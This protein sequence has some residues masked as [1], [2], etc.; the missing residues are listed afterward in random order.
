MEL[1]DI[2]QIKK[3]PENPRIIKN[4]KFDKLVKSIE[5][6]P[7]M[8]NIRPIVVDENY[9]VLGGNM[10]LRAC[11]KAGLKQVPVIK[12]DNLTTEQKKEFV[13]KDNSNFGEWDWT[14]LNSDW[15]LKLLDDWGIDVS[16]KSYK[17]KMDSNNSGTKLSDRFIAPPFSILDTKQGYWQER[18]GYWNDF[19]GEKG[20]SREGTLVKDSNC[21]YNA[22]MADGFA[23]VS[24]FDPVLAEIAFH[25]FSIP[26]TLIIDP[27]AG[28]TRKG[29]V[30][31]KLDRSFTGIE[32]RL[33]Q[34]EVNYK[35]IKAHKLEDKL[36][37]IC[38]SGTNI[39][40]HI[41]KGEADMIFSCPPYY[42]LEVYSDLPDDASN[43]DTYE[44]F[45]AM[46]EEAFVKSINLLND[47][48]FAVIVVGD[49][50]DDKGF[51]YDFPGDIKRI[52]MKNGMALYNDIILSDA[53]GSAGM[54][55]NQMMKNRKVVKVHQNVLVF[56]KGDPSQIKKDFPMIDY[57]KEALKDMNAESDNIQKSLE[58]DDVI[59]NFLKNN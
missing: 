49:V 32:L 35:K 54:R 11:Q 6:F 40:K 36:K 7:E 12:V 3:N 34:V 46:L 15:D 30:A 39:D 8:L 17:E 31:A 33:E 5:E 38:D 10:R 14:V 52:F 26:Q 4:D 23:N 45:I 57:D 19:L 18:K 37:Y 25:W 13:I 48:R 41:K 55:A 43:A 9:V 42:D 56:Y 44:D 47:N 20:E 27:F 59:K 1:I 58:I 51:Y 24:L 50:R 2:K 28:D 22:L 29:A 16:K 53:I 21:V